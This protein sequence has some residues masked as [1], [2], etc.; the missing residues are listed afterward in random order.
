M[1]IDPTVGRVMHYHPDRQTLD[2]MR[3][4]GVP[5]D[6]PWAAHVTY[7]HPLKEDEPQ[8]VNLM[9]IDPRGI[10]HSRQRVL[11]VQKDDPRP[12]TIDWCEW[13][14]YQL[15]QAAKTEEAEKRAAAALPAGAQS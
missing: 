12:G 11:L 8:L 6:Q 2:A 3:R 7:V 4:Q 5:L 13:M 15:G 9:V 10:S 14:S 1:T